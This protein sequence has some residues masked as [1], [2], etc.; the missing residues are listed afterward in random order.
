M[1]NEIKKA[2]D[3]VREN[4]TWSELKDALA[5]EKINTF[6][7]DIC[8]ADS[9]IADEIADLMEEYGADNDLPEGWWR[10]EVTEDDIFFEL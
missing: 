1:T 9:E 6:R 8:F 5:L 3:Y 2:I 10:T 4:K 7:C